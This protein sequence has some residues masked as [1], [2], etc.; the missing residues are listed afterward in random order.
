MVL[1]NSNLYDG[2]NVTPIATLEQA[3]LNE[4]LVQQ[5]RALVERQKAETF[6]EAW[7]KHWPAAV[8]SII[9][10]TALIMEGYDT[11]VVSTRK[12]TCQK[13]LTPPSLYR[14]IPSLVSLNLPNGLVSNTAKSTLFPP[15]IKRLSPTL[16]LVDSLSDWLLLVS[17]RSASA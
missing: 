15:K 9:L 6:W 5:G 7:A 16:Q 4:E 8:W 14:S 17:A 11:A 3:S 1:S 13:K 2:R 10:S 12:Q